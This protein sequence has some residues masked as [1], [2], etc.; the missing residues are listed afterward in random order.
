[1]KG[2]I[3]YYNPD[4]TKKA[5]I[6][7][8]NSTLAEILL[9]QKLKNKQLLGYDFHRQKPID[10]YIVDFFCPKLKLIIEIDGISHNEKVEYDKKRQKELENLGFKILRYTEYEVQK[11]NSDVLL[12]IMAFINENICG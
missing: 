9:W 3:I 1:M 4:L 2:K 7:R 12:S 10:K 5:R 6:L 8:K 11:K